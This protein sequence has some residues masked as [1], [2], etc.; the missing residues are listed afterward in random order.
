M[1]FCIQKDKVDNFFRN[2]F[3]QF[4]R[5]W[6]TTYI[7]VIFHRIYIFRSR[8]WFQARFKLIYN[9]IHSSQ[10]NFPQDS[11]SYF[12]QIYKYPDSYVK[13][14]LTSKIL[15]QKSHSQDSLVMM[16]S[17]SRWFSK[18]VTVKICDLRSPSGF[19]LLIFVCDFCVSK[20]RQNWKNWNDFDD[21]KWQT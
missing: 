17:F 15:P 18:G 2:I 5:K 8:K 9:K 20:I 19:T 11:H 14:S 13:I 1:I 16:K 3:M 10:I 7:T 12:F 21:F 4:T 6:Y